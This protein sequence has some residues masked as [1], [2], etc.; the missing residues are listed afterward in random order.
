MRVKNCR[1]MSAEEIK[2]V[3]L[4]ILKYVADFCEKHG[5]N[6][7]LSDGTLIGAVRHNGFIPWDD[8]IDI[9][10]LR[11]DYERFIEL[12]CRERHGK[13]ELLCERNGN[14]I[15]NYA[16]VVNSETLCFEGNMKKMSRSCWV[17]VF[18]LDF[19]PDSENEI[20]P[21]FEKMKVFYKQWGVSY[22]GK[23]RFGVLFPLYLVYA[24]LRNHRFS[25][26]FAYSER[27][28]VKKI[29]REIEKHPSG[30]NV[31]NYSVIVRTPP[32]RKFG[33]PK[34]CCT[35]YVY[36]KFERYEF[37]I[38]RDYDSVLKSFYGDYMQLPPEEKRIC[39]AVE[40]YWK[41]K[42]VNQ[43]FL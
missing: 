30:E 6:Y 21:H 22:F 9:S 37:R 34:S 25:Y 36:H 10:M 32:Q 35:D 3:E 7:I 14:Y 11:S 28:V 40:A 4:E 2:S 24:A 27:A 23:I 41:D 19:V 43:Y 5:I 12:W 20:A 16:K 15:S 39:H 1:R 13:F 42:K 38:P 26:L 18:P 17:D 29:K 31:T 33:F 8:D